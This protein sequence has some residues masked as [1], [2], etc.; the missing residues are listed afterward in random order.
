MK[1]SHIVVK[2]GGSTVF[3]FFNSSSFNSGMIGLFSEDSAVIFNN[4]GVA[5]F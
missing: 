3:D 1:G 2:V 5:P 4:L